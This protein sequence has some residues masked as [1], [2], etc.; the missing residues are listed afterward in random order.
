MAHGSAGRDALEGKGWPQRR[1][2]RRL[3]EVAK[4]VGGGYCRLHMPLKLALG[5]RDTVPGRRLGALEGGGGFQCIPGYG[6]DDVGGR[7]DT[8]GASCRPC[9]TTSLSVPQQGGHL[10]EAAV[11]PR[12]HRSSARK[13]RRMFV[14]QRHASGWRRGFG[15]PPGEISPCRVGGRSGCRACTSHARA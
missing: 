6:G 5:V 14:K 2:G 8:G 10:P 15:L 9:V 13:H 12:R 3:E 7:E 1:F 4:A 11:C